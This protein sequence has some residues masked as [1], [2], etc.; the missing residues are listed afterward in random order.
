MMFNAT[1]ATRT[2]LSALVLTFGAAFAPMVASA[3]DAGAPAAAGPAKWF[4]TCTKQEEADVCVVQNQQLAQNGQLIT[5]VG[6]ISIEG[7]INR[8]LIQVTVPS[9]R[10]IPPGIMMQ[11]DGGKG[12][13]L[14]YTVCLPD[15]CTAEMPLTD[16]LIASLKKGNEV[17]LTSV[18][19]RRAPNP[20]KIPLEGFTGAYDGEAMSQSQ[21]EER[22]RLL[23]EAMQKKQEERNKA[24]NDAQDAAKQGN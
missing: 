23:Q 20:I 14:D 19:F 7:K 2:A 13:K 24:I 18:N 1:K 5:A 3:Q 10:L 17:V 16:A 22:Q 4:K 11:I 9:A 21:A 15:R 12:V 6:L 8:K